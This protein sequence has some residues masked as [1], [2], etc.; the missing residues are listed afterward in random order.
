MTIIEKPP[1]RRIKVSTMIN[2][3]L[4]LII[5]L[6]VAFGWW[7]FKGKSPVD[8]VQSVVA[9]NLPKPKYLFTIYGPKDKHFRLPLSTT[10]FDSKIYVCDTENSRVMVYDYNG[11]LQFQFGKKGSHV[12]AMVAPAQVMVLNNEI[13]VADIGQGIILVHD[14]QGK[15][16]RI[17][18][19]LQF[20]KPVSI[21]YG[22]DRFYVLDN[23]SMGF[24][25]L[26]KNGKLIKFV[27][28]QG[29]KNS[30]F[31]CPDGIAFR[32]NKV[33]VADSNN[34]RIQIFDQDGKFLQ[35]WSGKN[36]EGN[37][38]YSIPRGVAFDSK[39]NLYTAEA[40]SNGVSITDINGI[41]LSFFSYAEPLNNGF[42]DTI[43]APTS[44]F[45]D[46][47]NRLY[48]TELGGSRV[49]VYE[50]L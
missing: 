29:N 24:N 23:G 46:N 21:A 40:L 19:K 15:F 22:N 31:Y 33:Y 16:K 18:G 17:L 37:G 27:G 12:G 8:T 44:V 11:K 49:L 48:V 35:V 20:V 25:I 26:D 28:Q 3:I 1:G 34:N 32:D 7:Y 2:I 13:Y 45:I 50:I 38:G 6:L 43:Q 5:V 47:N 4:G 30:E 14:M 10:V 9:G 39:G 36:A 41:K 42:E